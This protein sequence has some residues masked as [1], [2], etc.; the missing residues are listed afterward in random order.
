MH[1]MHPTANYRDE[2]PAGAHMAVACA[3]SFKG[4]IFHCELKWG[5]MKEKEKR[6]GK[7]RGKKMEKERKGRREKRR[8]GKS[9]PLTFTPAVPLLLLHLWSGTFFINYSQQPES[10]TIWEWAAEALN[11]NAVPAASAPGRG[12]SCAFDCVFHRGSQSP[13][14]LSSLKDSLFLI[15]FEMK[16][17]E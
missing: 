5:E 17:N 3:F 15:S 14:P 7:K 9:K 2:M 11:P 4:I 6:E 12:F 13:A 8:E 10:L 16:T 1:Q